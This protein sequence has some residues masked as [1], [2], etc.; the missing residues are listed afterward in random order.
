M[1]KKY[2]EAISVSEQV[3]T[4]LGREHWQKRVLLFSLREANQ[5]FST[6]KGVKV[7]LSKFFNT[8]PEEVV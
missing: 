6:E 5:K 7:G 3:R 4:G 8:S 2:S 1:E